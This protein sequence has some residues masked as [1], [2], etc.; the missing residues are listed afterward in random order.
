MLYR[1]YVP[2][3]EPNGVSM[4]IDV[5]AANW[6]LALRLG[7][8]EIGADREL[9]RRAICDIKPDKTIHVM[10]PVQ[11]RVFVLRELIEPDGGDP[12]RA[13]TVRMSPDGGRP[14]HTADPDRTP[15]RK[16]PLDE[17][18]REALRHLKPEPKTNAS[19]V[20]SDEMA[21]EVV[22]SALPDAL[23]DYPLSEAD[24]EK[25]FESS[26]PKRAISHLDLNFDTPPV[27]S[28][29]VARSAISPVALAE[30]SL[31]PT[32][33]LD[34]GNDPE[35]DVEV[36]AEPE[37]EP[38]PLAAKLVA[39]PP[40][41][42]AERTP[43]ELLAQVFE[44]MA[45]F[46]VAA[47]TIEEALEFALQ[48]AVALLPSEAG[49][50]LLAD[51]SRKDLYFAA[52]IGAKAAEV[53]EYR[54]PMGKGIAGFCAVNGVSLTLS[55]VDQDP[56]FQS[57]ISKQIGLELRSVAC[58]PIQHAG[59]VFGALQIMNHTG[60]KEYST[61]ELDVLSYIARRTAEFLAENAV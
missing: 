52:A 35:V 31:D 43:E 9:V 56:R 58:A 48:K 45:D 55:D 28:R 10:E 39:A 8:D 13:P 44:E 40:S 20:S 38:A 23:L 11:G 41:G 49:W 36:E 30:L 19:R 4:T 34:T 21:V 17:L 25:Y 29:V 22:V 12:Q 37:P 59:R 15:T 32:A 26:P 54:L 51:R 5:E 57:N 27:A 60:R 47:T 16:L 3:L 24:L 61:S 33:G 46:S 7:L 14:R 50:L 18:E 53:I 6:M 42:R 2:A 1:I